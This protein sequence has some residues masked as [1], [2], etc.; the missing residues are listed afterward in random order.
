MKLLEEMTDQESAIMT[1]SQI[2]S[3]VAIELMNE[4]VKAESKPALE[5][6]PDP[7]SPPTV[8]VWEVSITTHGSYAQAMATFDTPEDAQSFADLMPMRVESDYQSG[9]SYYQRGTYSIASRDITGQDEFNAIKAAAQGR[10]SIIARNE[11]RTEEYRKACKDFEAVNS[12]VYADWYRCL[13]IKANMETLAATFATY[14][15]HTEGNERMAF[16][17][18]SKAHTMDDIRQATEWSGS[19]PNEC[20]PD[21]PVEDIEVAQ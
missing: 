11:K 16:K 15:R 9:V 4:G 6:V 19:P 18:L 14:C 1:E 3:Q 10:K 17:F 21:Y 8:V 7:P 2:E 20:Y 13:D 5:P 12:S